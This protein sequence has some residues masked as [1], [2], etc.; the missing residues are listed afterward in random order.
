MKIYTLIYYLSFI[1][2][3]SCNNDF[4]EKYPLDQVSNNT[5]WNSENDFIAYS[6]HLHSLTGD[7]RGLVGINLPRANYCGRDWYDVY[8]PIFAPISPTIKHHIDVN[9]GMHQIPEVPVVNGYGG[10]DF[11]RAVNIG[12]D[13]MLESGVQQG[14]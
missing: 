4:L 12:I 2:L 1:V 9:A 11:V 6:N 14:I 8:S 7:T 3:F 10:W 5:F 13:N